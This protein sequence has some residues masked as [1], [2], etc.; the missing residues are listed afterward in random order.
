[1]YCNLAK[2]QMFKDPKILK[3]FKLKKTLSHRS[4]Y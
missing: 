2:N 3:A 1:M 4:N